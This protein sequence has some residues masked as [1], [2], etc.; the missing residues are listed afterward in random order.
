MI[1]ES[2]KKEKDNFSN[3]DFWLKTLGVV[4]SFFV[5]Y[6]LIVNFKVSQHKKKLIA[7]IN[8]YKS[9]IEEIKKNNAEIADKIDNIDDIGYLEKLG[10]E[11]FN[12]ARP[13]ETEYMFINMPEKNEQVQENKNF[14]ESFMSRLS[15][16]FNLN[17]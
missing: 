8:Q 5:L 15:G 4:L 3:K 17:K 6:M 9:Q 14:W 11:Q 13:G 10:Y 1:S 2:G 7:Q 16:I 12:Q